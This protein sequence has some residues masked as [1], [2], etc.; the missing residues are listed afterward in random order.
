M[1]LDDPG[2]NRI[3]FGVP[4]Q[5]DQYVSF[6]KEQIL[7][8]ANDFQRLLFFC[9]QGSDPVQPDPGVLECLSRIGLGLSLGDF[10]RDDNQGPSNRLV[11]G[12]DAHGPDYQIEVVAVG[13]EGTRR[14]VQAR[15][16]VDAKLVAQDAL[17]ATCIA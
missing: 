9:R 2:E 7:V 11:V 16:V 15:G 3:G 10:Q 14:I 1:Q 17:R 5:L 4:A 12:V 6:L 8:Q 13:N